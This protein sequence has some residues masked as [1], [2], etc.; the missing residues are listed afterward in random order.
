MTADFNF[1]ACIIGPPQFGKTTLARSLMGRHLADF[2]DGIV[3]AHDPLQQFGAR[4]YKTP[5]DVRAAF[6]AAE[7][8]PRLISVTS[9]APGCTSLAYEIGERWNTAKRTTRPIL[10]C[11]DEGSLIGSSGATWMGQADK[12]ALAVRRHRGVGLVYNLQRYNQFTQSFY[13]SATDLYLF[14]QLPTRLA[15]IEEALGLHAGTLKAAGADTLPQ[16]HYLHLRHH[17]GVVSEVL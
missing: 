7:P 2:K 9:D 12:E 3:I 17:V 10:L 11:Y 16:H 14:C 5:A 15:A 8:M 4:S 1:A 6:I 13:D